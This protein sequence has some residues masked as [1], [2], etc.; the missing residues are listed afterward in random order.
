ME[1]P[2]PPAPRE[3]ARSNPSCPQAAEGTFQ[4]EGSL[5]RALSAEM[6]ERLEG[7]RWSQ[8]R[9][10]PQ[11]AR[12]HKRLFRQGSRS[13]WHR[14]GARLEAALGR[15]WGPGHCS[16]YRDRLRLIP[17]TRSSQALDTIGATSRETAEGQTSSSAAT[18]ASSRQLRDTPE[19]PGEALPSA[20]SLQGCGRDVPSSLPSSGTRAAC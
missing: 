4:L 2:L 3:A 11:H 10:D 19:R 14:A 12:G 5:G 20:G 9:R 15:G 8:R 1:P 17:W 18:V 16:S 13:P 7:R 6:P